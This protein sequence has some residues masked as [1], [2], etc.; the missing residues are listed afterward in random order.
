M[1][2]TV[3][4]G[5]FNCTF[6]SLLFTSLFVSYY[7]LLYIGTILGG[8]EKKLTIEPINILH[9]SSYEQLESVS[10]VSSESEFDG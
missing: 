6:H 5:P 3:A 8:E 10:M 1:K 2:D 7:F 4:T 9:L